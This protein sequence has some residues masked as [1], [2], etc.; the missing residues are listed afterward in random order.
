MLHLRHNIS[1][2]Q[3]KAL[4]VVLDGLN[5]QFEKNV[6]ASDNEFE[7]P[8]SFLSEAKKLDCTG[9]KSLKKNFEN[10]VS[11]TYD[12]LSEDGSVYELVV[13]LTSARYV[14]GERHFSVG[15]NPK[16]IN[17]CRGFF[18]NKKEG[19]L[20]LPID[21]LRRLTSPNALRFYELFMLYA[22]VN[23]SSITRDIDDIKEWL[24]IDK[25]KYQGR[26]N[27][28]KARVIESPR[29]EIIENTNLYYDFEVMKKG[30]TVVGIKFFNITYKG[31]KKRSKGLNNKK[32]VQSSSKEFKELVGYGI[33]IEEAEECAREYPSLEFIKESIKTTDYE[34]TKK[35]IGNK[36]GYLVRV[37]GKNWKGFC[38]KKEIL[39][40]KD[41]NKPKRAGKI[42]EENMKAEQV[43]RAEMEKCLS[44]FRELSKQEQQERIKAYKK[45]KEAVGDTFFVEQVIEETLA[46]E[47]CE[48]IG[49][50][51]SSVEQTV[52]DM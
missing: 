10:V 33:R 52:L 36:Q 30:R 22:R 13:P 24:G 44:I 32:V 23:R 37:L 35:D 46:R 48:E 43:K 19:I 38:E 40:T 41:S 47:Y 1:A 25:K 50:I 11:I 16:F 34:S 49:A 12:T 2:V 9:L 18:R 4:N 8:V 20:P 7:I 6:E 15:V 27:N 42:I 5:N 28:F 17:I 39:K 45:E 31:K 3:H 26:I 21:E 29:K 14:K 51:Q